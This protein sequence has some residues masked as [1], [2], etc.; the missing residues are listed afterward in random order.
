MFPH[1]CS[2]SLFS[3]KFLIFADILNNP[4]NICRYLC[5]KLYLIFADFLKRYKKSEIHQKLS[6]SW[7]LFKIS[8][9]IGKISLKSAK[10]LKECSDIRVETR[11]TGRMFV[12]KR[13]KFV[14][15]FCGFLRISENF[16]GTT[17]LYAPNSVV[18]CN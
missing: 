5:I 14:L 18:G 11:G 17:C 3:H 4:Q 8:A 16:A 2:Y 13:V 1:F 6:K 9:K 10:N 15:K 7:G 12:S